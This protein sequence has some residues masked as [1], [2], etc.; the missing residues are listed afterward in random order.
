MTRPAVFLDRDGTL[1]EDVG[2]VRSPE[3]LVWFPDTEE[4]LGLLAPHFP[5]FVVTNQPG[6]S[7]G[8]VT[9][10]EVEGVHEQMARRLGEAGAP[11]RAFYTC[12]HQRAEGCVCV[13]PNPHFLLRAAEEHGI[14]LARSFVVGDHPHDMELARRVGATGVYLLTGHGAQHRDELGGLAD[15]V[16]PGIG[17][18]ARW[19]LARAR[20]GI[21][22]AEGIDEAARALREGGL[23]AFPTETVYGLGAHALDEAAVARVF[24]AKGRPRFDPLIVHLGAAEDLPAVAAEVPA[25]ARELARR[26]WPGPLTLVLPRATRVPDLVT[27]GLPT[28]AVRVPSH[29]LARELLARAGVPVAAPSA[30]RFGRTS[31]TRAEHV[32]EELAGRVDLVLDGGPCPLGVESTIVSLAGEPRL[33]RP[34][35]VPVEEIERVTGPLARGAPKPGLAPGTL[36]SHYAPRTPLVLVDSLDAPNLPRGRLGALAF[37]GSPPGDRFEAVETLSPRGDLREAAARLFAALR[38]LDQAGLDAIVAEAV[39]AEGLGLAILDRLRRAAAG[40]EAP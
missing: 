8:E 9:A 38:R 14:D 4:A 39:P 21:V 5:L 6:I 18:A 19:I 3:D 32:V 22:G 13:K 40:S 35:A 2:F 12:P 20:I 16:L 29:P 17:E 23:V 15:A 11:I 7:L 34:G 10:H 37:R 28:V 30:N 25:L 27:A 31:P 36:P 1:V 26:F 33:L 24:E